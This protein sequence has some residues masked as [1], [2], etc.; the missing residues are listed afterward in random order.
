MLARDTFQSC[1]LRLLEIQSSKLSGLILRCV[2]KS[3]V[4]VFIGGALGD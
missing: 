1:F 2:L 4:P 3:P